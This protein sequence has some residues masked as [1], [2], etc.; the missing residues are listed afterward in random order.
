MNPHYHRQRKLYLFSFAISIIASFSITSLHAESLNDFDLSELTVPKKFIRSGGLPKDGI[1]SIEQPRFME[2]EDAYHL[3]VT[4]RVLGVVVDGMARAYPIKIL[5]KHEIVNDQF[6]DKP[7]VVTYCPLSGSGMAFQ[8]YVDGPK[9]FGV[10]GLLYNSDVLI[11]DRETESLWSQ[12]MGEAVSG[13]MIGDTL[14]RI[15]TSNTTWSTWKAKHPNTR[16]LSAEQGIY[17]A[18]AYDR[19]SYPGY[20]ESK[21]IWFPI[22]NKNRKIHPKEVVLGLELNGEFK[23]YPIKELEAKSQT[24]CIDY[25]AGH[26]LIIEIE[27]G[28]ASAVIRDAEGEILPA[29]SLYWFAWYAFHPDTDIFTSTGKSVTKKRRPTKIFYDTKYSYARNRA[30]NGERYGR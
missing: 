10:S 16:V 19:N 27:P 26:E 7:V 23:A 21:R 3:R 18:Y 30:R 8:S 25:F 20:T 13:P 2:A 6:G 4:D 5:D 1:P 29:L 22:E 15:P 12:I 9:R 11:Y 17:P 28:A 24:P 14:E